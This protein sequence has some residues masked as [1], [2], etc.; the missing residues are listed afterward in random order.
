MSLDEILNLPT[1]VFSSYDNDER[2]RLF[3][4]TSMYSHYV[5]VVLYSTHVVQNVIFHQ[6]DVDTAVHITVYY[7]LQ[8]YVLR[9]SSNSVRWSGILPS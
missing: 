2:R 6:K 9:I 1:D 3:A 7:I 4:N 8:E 5:D